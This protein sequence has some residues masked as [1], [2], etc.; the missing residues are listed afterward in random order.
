[1]SAS[2]K[3]GGLVG[4]RG[5]YIRF[6]SSANVRD[7]ALTEISSDVIAIVQFEVGFILNFYLIEAIGVQ[8]GIEVPRSVGREV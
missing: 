1:M 7:P 4:V 8:S 6:A 5:M 3:P 2:T